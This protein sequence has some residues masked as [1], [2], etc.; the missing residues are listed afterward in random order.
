MQEM[1]ESHCTISRRSQISPKAIGKPCLTSFGSM[2]A[3]GFGNSTHEWLCFGCGQFMCI[4]HS[5]RRIILNR[6]IL[7]NY[8]LSCLVSASSVVWLQLVSFEHVTGNLGRD[9]T[10]KCTGLQ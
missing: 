7:V 9:G 10:G 6:K 1:E 5:I 8:L 3:E 4:H 2:L